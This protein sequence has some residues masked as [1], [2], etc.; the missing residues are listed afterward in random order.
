MKPAN[1]RIVTTVIYAVI[2]A[3]IFV[4][5]DDSEALKNYAFAMVVFIMSRRIADFIEER[6]QEERRRR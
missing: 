2:A 6:R 1:R 3:I 4:D 5:H